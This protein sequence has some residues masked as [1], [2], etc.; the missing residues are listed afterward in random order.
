MTNGLVAVRNSAGTSL[1]GVADSG[2]AWSSSAPLALGPG[3]GLISTG[4]ESNGGFVVL[5]S[6][7]DGALALDVETGPA[8]GWRPLPAP[9][10]T[11]ATVAVGIGGEVDALAVASTKLT[12]WQL[13]APAGT[14]SKIGTVTVPIQFGSSA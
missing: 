8:G 1:I 7:S 11:T 2:G 14:W 6:R 4:V 10:P 12:D 5:T 13:D 9:P 3:D